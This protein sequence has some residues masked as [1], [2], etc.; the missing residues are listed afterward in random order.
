MAIGSLLRGGLKAAGWAGV[1]A[2]ADA[3]GVSDRFVNDIRSTREQNRQQYGAVQAGI[4]NAPTYALQGVVNPFS[5][6]QRQQPVVAAPRRGEPPNQTRTAVPA[7]TL[8]A[9]QTMLSDMGQRAQQTRQQGAQA[10]QLIDH[11]QR[12]QGAQQAAAQVRQPQAPARGGWDPAAAAAAAA[13]GVGAVSET[14]NMLDPMMIAQLNARARAAASAVDAARTDATE[15]GRQLF[16]RQA[17]DAWQKAGR[18]GALGSGAFKASRGSEIGAGMRQAWRGRR[19]GFDQTMDDLGSRGQAFGGAARAAMSDARNRFSEDRAG[20]LAGGARELSAL[21]KV[22]REAE[23]RRA[24]E[25]ATIE[26]VRAQ[27]GAGDASALRRVL[28]ALS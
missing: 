28:E 19:S 6:G 17:F 2:A 18:Q 13:A 10:R 26:E 11:R 12:L 15:R 22:A 24:N 7:A 3:A 27:A 1:G 5:F 20:L 14:P 23:R 21:E 8:Q 9:R 16:G 4:R 25:R